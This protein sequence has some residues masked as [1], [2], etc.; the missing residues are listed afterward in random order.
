MD[1]SYFVRRLG[2]DLVG[3][4]SPGTQH[5]FGDGVQRVEA[6]PATQG[7]QC[8]NLVGGYVAQADIGAEALDQIR[9]LVFQ[10]R[11]PAVLNFPRYRTL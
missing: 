6:Q 2:L 5:V 9:L 10:R 7:F 4:P 3:V 8:Q 11:L 1:D